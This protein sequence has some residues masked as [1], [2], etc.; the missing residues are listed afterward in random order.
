MNSDIPPGYEI[1]DDP[2]RVDPQAAWDFLSTQ[3]YWARWRTFEDVRAQ[4][5]AAWRVVGCYDHD[6]R[7]V[8]FAR[9]I[10]DGVS[11]AYLADVY[12]LPVHR[13][14]GLGQALIHMMIDNGPG[15]KFRWM[16][17]TDDAHDLYRTFG[18]AAADTTYMERPR[19]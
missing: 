17:H 11:L 13:G 6:G 18:F 19:R 2:A 3:A 15:A 5:N 8:G 12:I 1:D 9:A 10:S 4:L 16:L 14:R 7:M